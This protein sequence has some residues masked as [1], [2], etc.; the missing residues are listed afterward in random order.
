[1][2]AF[3]RIRFLL[4]IIWH[5]HSI[6]RNGRFLESI[7][8]RSQTAELQLYYVESAPWQSWGA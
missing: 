2:M 1:M 3:L 7:N 4:Q 5:E 8:V 6:D